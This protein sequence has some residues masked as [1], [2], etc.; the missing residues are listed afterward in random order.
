MEINDPNGDQ[1]SI[2]YVTNGLLV[3][4]MITGQLQLGDVG[5]ETHDP[6]QVNVT[7]DLDDA[8]APT[9]VTF[10]SL[11]D[12]PPFPADS[13]IT[14]TLDRN[15][16]IGDDPGLA[17]YGVTVGSPVVETK[18]TVASAFWDFMNSSGPVLENGSLHD[19]PLFQNP[20]YATGYPISEP[21]WT[22]VKVGGDMKWVLAQAF[23]RRVLTYTPDNPDG[24]RVE[25]GNVGQHY[26][27][28]RYS[29]LGTS[30]I[31]AS[32]PVAHGFDPGKYTGQ[33]DRYNCS[34][35]A[36]QAEVQAVLRADPSDRNRLDKDGNG[37]ACERAV[38][39]RRISYL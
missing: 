29:Q 25:A 24:W 35:F 4:E 39:V 10:A 15:G 27:Q 9:Y 37:I 20:F 14:R 28:W 19:A 3:Q 2:W 12:S 16:N 26:Y 21:Y 33:G 23:E 5:F 30:P 7:G 11:L 22:R 38:L 31:P 36:S 18:H 32:S 8:N 13:T 34:D 1:S 6:A 17:A